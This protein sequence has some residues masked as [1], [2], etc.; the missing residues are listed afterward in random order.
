MLRGGIRFTEWTARVNR[1]LWGFTY[2]RGLGWGPISTGAL[3][4]FLGD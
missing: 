3:V 2:S 4:N 1:G